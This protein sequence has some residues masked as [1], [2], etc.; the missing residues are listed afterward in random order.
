MHASII[1]TCF[2]RG[3]RARIFESCISSLLHSSD[4]PFDIHLVDNTYDNVGLG[5]ARNAA[6]QR[7]TGEYLAIV[8]DDIAFNRD[9]LS[10]CIKLLANHKD[11]K[12]I[13]TPIH[14]HIPGHKKFEQPPIDGHRVNLRSGSNCMVMTRSSFMDI[15]PFINV[16]PAK[17]GVE[18]C[19]R[20]VRKGYRVIMTKHELAVDLAFRQHSYVV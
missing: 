17:D 8:D 15:G 7:S 9:W 19:D 1:M 16:H 4:Y 20:Q 2:R 6:I 3:D 13:A 10:E 18:F 12:L 11:L 5:A 14:T